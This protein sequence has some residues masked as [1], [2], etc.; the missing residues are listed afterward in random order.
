MATK[1]SFT[2]Q[3][4]QKSADYHGGCRTGEIKPRKGGGLNVFITFA[5]GCKLQVALQAALVA[6]NRHKR[7][8]AVGK[9][10]GLGFWLDPASHTLKVY[11]QKQS[12]MNIEDSAGHG[13]T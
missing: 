8:T 11:E 10:M 3:P 4:D 6:L 12:A 2:P 13:D 9:A 1:R 7:S 5:E